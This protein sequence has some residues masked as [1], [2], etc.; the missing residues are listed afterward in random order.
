MRY[1]VAIDRIGKNICPSCERAINFK[2][3]QMAHCPHCGISVFDH[4][5]GCRT[6]KNAFTRFCFSCGTPANAS[7]AD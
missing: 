4:C 3:E 2:D 7:L 6:R 1:D 5:L